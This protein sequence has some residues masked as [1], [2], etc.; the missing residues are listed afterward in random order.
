MSPYEV[1]GLSETNF[2]YK[3][4]KKQY[5]KLSKKYHPDL[6]TKEDENDLDFNKK[7]YMVKDAYSLLKDP[8]LKQ[9]FDLYGLGWKYNIH[10]KV[11]NGSELRRTK[12]MSQEEFRNYMNA[13]SFQERAHF[14]HRENSKNTGFNGHNPQFFKN[15]FL[16]TGKTFS[17]WEILGWAIFIIYFIRLF[18]VI[19]AIDYLSTNEEDS[20]LKD[21]DWQFLMRLD[22]IN[23][24][25]NHGLAVQDPWNRIRRFL[26]FRSFENVHR[27]KKVDFEEDLETGKAVYNVDLINL[28]EKSA[29]L[30]SFVEEN[31]QHVQNL[32]KRLS[33]Q[34]EKHIEDK[35]AKELESK[36]EDDNNKIESNSSKSG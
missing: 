2:N 14:Y 30:G 18:F 13:S 7:F 3:E 25:T 8:I 36:N 5:Y 29:Q 17:N 28:K 26:F 21:A 10:A 15:G 6:K 4:A 34:K 19:G 23:A 22:L 31:E 9:Q 32:K 16:L 11:T 12:T 33:V 27:T 24:Y 20:N 1:L 35:I